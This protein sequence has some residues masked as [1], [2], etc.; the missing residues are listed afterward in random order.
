M[1]IAVAA[2]AAL[3]I[4][5]RPLSIV[6]TR[7][8]QAAYKAR[9]TAQVVAAESVFSLSE[10]C[11]TA[12]ISA[13]RPRVT[14]GTVHPPGYRDTV[15]YESVRFRGC[16]RTMR[17]NLALTPRQDYGDWYPV[18]QLPGAGLADPGVQT[19]ALI[20]VLALIQSTAP[21][22][23]SMELGKTLAI[24]DIA[25]ES[26]KGTVRFVLQG[27]RPPSQRNLRYREALV[28]VTEAALAE[29][30]DDRQAWRERWPLSACGQ[31]RTVVVLFAPLKAQGA[32]LVIKVSPAWRS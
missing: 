13:P 18:R 20:D 12:E 3:L 21:G 17:V 27:R 30:L 7:E 5:D 2:A 6:G 11:P 23:C 14:D 28:T 9:L 26:P 16:G 19:R 31:D 32:G 24:G 10:P 29:A 25:V 8:N 22:Q 4:A 1:L 15:A